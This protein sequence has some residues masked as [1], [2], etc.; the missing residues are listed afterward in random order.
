[1]HYFLLFGVQNLLKFNHFLRGLLLLELQHQVFKLVDSC[2][3]LLL[4]LN[5]DVLRCIASMA[6][7]Q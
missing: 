3:E 7:L 2:K 5:V 1:M 4:V 6:L